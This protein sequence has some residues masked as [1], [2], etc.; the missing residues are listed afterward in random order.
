MNLESRG[1][2]SA[3][4]ASTEFVD[5]AAAQG[6]SLEITPASLFVTHPIKARSEED[7]TQLAREAIEQIKRLTCS[8]ALT[9]T[10]PTTQKKALHSK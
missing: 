6:R 5:A 8:A 4:I 3:F 9:K 10:K 1:L 7:M 2:P